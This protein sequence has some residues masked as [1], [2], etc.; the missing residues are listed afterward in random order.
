M[1]RFL[2]T[3]SLICSLVEWSGFEKY[4]P[5][6]GLLDSLVVK[7]WLQMQGV[8]GSIPS[9]GPSHTKDVIKNGTSNSLVWNSTLKRETLALSEEL[10]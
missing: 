7:C 3:Q 6:Y 10:R 5:S 2:L 8:P 4:I 9:Q 1:D